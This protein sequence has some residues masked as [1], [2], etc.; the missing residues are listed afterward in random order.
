MSVEIEAKLRVESHD[1]VRRS[2]GDLRA[3][4]LGQVIET[5]H[6]LDRADRKLGAAGAALRL[7][8]T[9]PVQ[10]GSGGTTLTFKGPVQRSSFKRREEMEVHV[11]DAQAMLDLLGALG[12]VEVM[13][14]RKRR[15][16]YRLEQC[17]VELDEVPLLGN[18][19]EIEGPD[20]A[21]IRHVQDRLGLAGV[22]HIAAGYVS[23][24][25]DHCARTGQD[26]R[27]I[28]FPDE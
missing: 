22:K 5:N 25:A 28:D 15:E 19:V 16:S 13:A 7:R 12:F 26:P 23:L 14:Y 9:E 1:P 24:L 4:T 18:F 17:R 10:E 21:S 6:T 11:A 20:E 3:V 27:W 8:T 2:L